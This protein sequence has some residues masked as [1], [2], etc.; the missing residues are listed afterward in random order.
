VLAAARI[1]KTGADGPRIHDFRHTF[2]VRRVLQWYRQGR[3]V[4]ALLPVLATYM[5]HVDIASTQVYLDAAAQLLG[6]VNER[7][8]NHFQ[9]H[10]TGRTST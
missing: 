7:F 10:I 8:H 6:P 4:N 1:P 9:Q 3:D 5:G 2:A